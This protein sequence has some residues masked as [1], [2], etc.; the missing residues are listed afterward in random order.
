[1]LDLYLSWATVVQKKDV[2]E[3][4]TNTLNIK[5]IKN[6]ANVVKKVKAQ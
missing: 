5:L 2:I 4:Y 1:M 6:I 3:K